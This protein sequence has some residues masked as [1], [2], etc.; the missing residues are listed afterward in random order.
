MILLCGIPS[1]T[2]LALVRQRLDDYGIPY[3]LFSQRKFERMRMCFEL[4][5]GEL[6]GQL[7]IDGRVYLLEHFSAVYT[8]LMDDQH[9]PEVRGQPPGSPLRRHA[10]RLH[11]TMIRWCEVAPIRVV[12]RIGPMGSNSSKPFQ[13]QAIVKSGFRTPETLITNDP[14]LVRDFEKA[15]GKLIFKSMSGVRSIVQTMNETDLGRLNLIRWCPVQFQQFVEGRNVR[16]HTVGR[17]VFATGIITDATDYRYASRQV[18]DAAE[19]ESVELS[20]ELSARALRLVESLELPFAG[21][22]LKIAPDGEVY[23]LEVNPSP[24]YSYYEAH[25]GQ[26]ISDA[27]AQYLAGR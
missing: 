6:V 7:V 4:S 18:G 20:A 13:A 14:D 16:V 2:P 1:E 26:P 22:D 3:V 25:T 10:R 23:C 5:H 9:L 17:S 12:N 27:L 11:D 15:H 19:L 21:I 24:A 8:R